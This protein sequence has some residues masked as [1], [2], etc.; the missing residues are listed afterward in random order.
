VGV[1]LSIVLLVLSALLIVG[2]DVGGQI[3]SIVIAGGILYY[4]DTPVPRHPGREAGV[5]SSLIRSSL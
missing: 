4:L 5:R 2:G 1:A 3:V